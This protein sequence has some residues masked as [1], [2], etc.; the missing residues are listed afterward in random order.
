MLR[1]ED[2]DIQNGVS[3]EEKKE[4]SQQSTDV[5]RPTLLQQTPQNKR[6]RFAVKKKA[7]K[8]FP[9]TGLVMKLKY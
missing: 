4:S 3:D 1:G 7:S 9:K 8:I 5:I 2:E 6:G